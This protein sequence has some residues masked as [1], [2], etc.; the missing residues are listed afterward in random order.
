[1][2][3]APAQPGARATID[4]RSDGP[5]RPGWGVGPDWETWEVPA[6]P[7]SSHLSRVPFGSVERFAF[8]MDVH[9][10]AVAFLPVNERSLMCHATTVSFTMRINMQWPVH[11]P[12]RAATGTAR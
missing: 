1:M 10:T 7:A 2:A 8:G 12:F 9:G 6:H 11:E 5:A 4:A 3:L